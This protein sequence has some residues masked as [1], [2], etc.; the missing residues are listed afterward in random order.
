M[1][2]VN[3]MYLN[4]L[5]IFA[6]VQNGEVP[7][8]HSLFTV[9]VFLSILGFCGY[10]VVRFCRRGGFTGTRVAADETRR[11]T[12]IDNKFLYGRKYITLVECCGKRLLILVSR[13]DAVKLTEWEV[14][15]GEIDR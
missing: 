6:E 9:L 12:I 15:A 13:D 8:V 2:C 3:A 5:Q 4:A 7:F 11:I 10:T 1:E 14:S